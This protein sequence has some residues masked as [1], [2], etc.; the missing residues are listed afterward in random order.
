MS[1]LAVVARFLEVAGQPA[2]AADP[3]EGALDDPALGLDDEAG[4]IGALDD[5]DAPAAR[6]ASCLAHARPL[7]SGIGKDR[8]DEWKAPP[9]RACQD[10]RRAVAVLD[11]RRM[12]HGSQQKALVVGEDVALDPLD[13]LA[14]IEADRVNRA[15]PFCI[16]LALWLS[17][18]A[19]EGLA[20]RPSCSRAAT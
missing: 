5:L 12:D 13:L 7:V 3:G 10:E 17:R 16:D 18:R 6:A 11:A 20:S 1:A 9:H 14:R 2:V 8:R 15:P 19:A 4:R